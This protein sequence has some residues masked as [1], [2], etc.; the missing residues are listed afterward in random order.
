MPKPKER[1][2]S[3]IG[4]TRMEIKLIEPETTALATPKENQI[5]VKGLNNILINF[6]KCCHP[7]HG[8]E[9]I[10]F[11]SAGRGIIIHRSIC[12]NVS[13]FSSTR[14]IEASWKPIEEKPKKKK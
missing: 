7:M 5:A 14:L 1:I 3:I 6:A 11:V 13:Y 10:G 12:P 2:T 4:S 9:I 8:D